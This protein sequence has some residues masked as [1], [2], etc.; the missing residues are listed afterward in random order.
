LAAPG[1]PPENKKLLSHP[2]KVEMCL[3]LVPFPTAKENSGRKEHLVRFATLV[4]LVFALIAEFPVVAADADQQRVDQIFAVFGKAGSPGCALGV[5]RDGNFI[6]RKGYGTAS[7]ELGVPL[8]SQ[9]V[10]YMGSISK[11]FT[12]AGVVLAA[13]QG[14]L[15]LDDDVRKYIMELP[16]YGH[17]ITLRQMLHHTSGLRD[18]LTLLDMSGRHDSDL[19]SSAEMIDLIARQKGLN[20]IPGDE[21]IYSNTNYFLLGEVVKRATKKSLAE[22]AAENIFKPLGMAHTRFYDDHTLVVPGRVS[23]YESGSGGNFLVDWST[24]FDT[25]G[26]GGLM[27]SV[28]D[29]LLWDQNFYENKLGKGTL[30]KELQT[31]GVLNNGKQIHY[32]LGLEVGTYRGLPIVEHGGALFGYRTEILRFPKQRF[33]VVSLC[34]LASADPTS[35]SRSVADVFLEK[36]LQAEASAPQPPGGGGFPDPS[37]FAGKYLDPRT[38]S[39]ASF[40]VSAGN[41]SAWGASLKREGPNR[42]KYPGGGTTTFDS[43]DGTMKASLDLDGQILFAG[44]RMEELHLNDVALAAFVGRYRS[45]ELDASYKLSVEKG[46]LILRNGWNPAL[47]LNPIAQDEFE[48]GDLG[49]LVFHRDANHR[50]SGLSVFSSRVRNVSFDKTN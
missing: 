22:F 15:S 23:A 7:L 6:Y 14:F 30:L 10:F 47:E 16:D 33:T 35:L 24:N 20:N 18:F 50:V 43:P 17:A 11:Q 34:N 38:H 31:R 25:V 41:L 26:A 39:V 19:H 29:L 12:A 40:T 37:V 3:Q 45:T 21:F 8:S 48:S 27:S 46:T 32:A 2:E 13:E 36:S 44:S 9:S 28:N 5:I 1:S 4:T 42:F 49:T